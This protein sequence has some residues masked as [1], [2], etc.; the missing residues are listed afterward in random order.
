MTYNRN[1]A[2][3]NRN[4]TVVYIHVIIHIVMIGAVILRFATITARTITRF[5]QPD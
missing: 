4:L 5:T 1:L 2:D 3:V